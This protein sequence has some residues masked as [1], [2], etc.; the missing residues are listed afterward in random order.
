[1][2]GPSVPHIAVNR[3]Y[4]TNQ[5]FGKGPRAHDFRKM[6]LLAFGV[7]HRSAPLALRER[8]NIPDDALPSALRALNACQDVREA[9][10]LSTCNR[11][12][13]YCGLSEGSGESAIDWFRHYHK[14]SAKEWNPYQY[15]RHSDHAVR[16]I[17][18]VASGLDSMILGEPQILGQIKH[19]YR[20]AIRTGTVGHIL[21][22]LFQQSFAVAKQVRTDTAI[23][24]S[25]VSVAFAAVRLA[26]QIFGELDNFTALMMGAGE[27]IELAAR[28]LKSNGLKRLIIAN[29]TV[30]GAHRLARELGGF[31]IGLKEIAP[32]LSEAD[33]I[34]CSTASREHILHRHDFQT[35][36]SGR[37]RRPIFVADL[38][39]PRDVEPSVA[40]LEDI[41]LYT[42]DDLEGVIKD[43]L[44]HREKAAF[45]AEEIID[46]K[47]SHFMG[48]L[49]ALDTVP[50]IRRY[51]DNARSTRVS[52]LE[53]ARRLIRN[54]AS[55]D[56]ALN[57][58]ANTLTNKLT[59]SPTVRIREAG[60]HSRPEIIE[61]AR[62]LLDIKDEGSD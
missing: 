39:V 51:R 62:I 14:L 43:N 28:H 19:A 38:A 50:T 44:E 37:K 41:Y 53:K 47:V 59:H 60:A 21:G 8:V 1:M 57:Y 34:F 55:V 40:E 15:V 31:G 11:T 30:E 48:W 16:H 12:D 49:G 9:A 61:A 4:C 33:I 22:R 36:F 17:M 54:G 35:A 45:Q 29:R 25:P 3:S 24:S 42:V 6:S 56:E 20:T 27:T 7:N 46:A 32:H 18:R 58:L 23:G 26:Q 2:V 52:V 13:L 5:V 10:I